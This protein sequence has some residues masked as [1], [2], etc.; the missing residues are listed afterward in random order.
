MKV[1]SLFLPASLISCWLVCGCALQATDQAP[2][3]AP[4]VVE[5]PAPAPQPPERHFPR[6][7]LYS[8]LVAE[9][10]GSRQQFDIALSNYA[11]QAKETRDP[12]VAERATMIARFL[13]EDEIAMESAVIWAEA[14]P[15]SSEALANASMTLM[16]NGRHLE[17]FEMSRHLLD[18][19][20][21][22]LFQN[23]AANATNLTDDERAV[24]LQKYLDQLVTHPKDEQLLVGA[25][26]LLQQQEKLD[27]ALGYAQAALTQ[28]PNSIPA[29]ILEANLLH[30]LQRDEEAIARM[31]ALL[32]QYPDNIRLRL[33]YARILTHHDLGLAQ[34]QF[35]ILAEQSPNDGDLLLSLGI[36][37][38]ERKDTETA[39]IA[40]EKL[41]D[42]DQHV[43]TAHY[44]LGRL[45]EDRKDTETALIHYL[46]V[47]PG[48]D[49]LPATINLLNI[50]ISSGD[51][52]SATEHMKRILHRFPDQAGGLNLIHAQTLI[53]HN[54]LDAGE[55][56]LN[57]ALKTTPAEEQSNLLFTRAML[58]DQRNHLAAAEEDLRT[59][60]AREPDNAAALNALG[61]ILTDKTTRF[62]EARELLVKAY[63]L[64]PDDPAIIDSVGWL[65]YRT[66][67]YP[68]ALI[69]LR[70]AYAAYQD[71]EIAAH[72]GEVLWVI[73]EKDEARQIW[74]DALKLSPGSEVITST[75]QRL[76][77][78][79]E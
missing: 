70:R 11:Q 15:D 55:A 77:A 78:P 73:G 48:N 64:N 52:L 63:T 49:F 33:Q 71:A 8:L 7:T 39:V 16:Q 41:L 65:H 40:F 67:N 68:E 32:E 58:H 72:L 18:K 31:T 79:R 14:A 56:V 17:A 54:Y 38:L 43:S 6:E 37:A 2:K 51:L 27:E 12:Q 4:I 13:R 19:G 22:T 1:G 45:A 44:Y 24:L 20:E 10:A 74:E 59:V 29:A 47:E 50:M 46:Q 23:I 9:I 21:E 60:L 28:K 3:P 36:I 62:E 66:G 75:M 69:Y 57:R 30:Q 5:E 34:E 25:G 26:I 53:K 42:R 61:Y 76:K 35:E